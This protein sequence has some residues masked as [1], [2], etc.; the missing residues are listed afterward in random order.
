MTSRKDGS[1]KEY[2]SIYITSFLECVRSEKQDHISSYCTSTW[3]VS[4]K[5]YADDS[6]LYK[7]IKGI[8]DQ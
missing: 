7:E 4:L 5:V 3:L 2:V 6:N 8:K 1:A